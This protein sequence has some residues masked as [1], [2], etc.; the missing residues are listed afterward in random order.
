MDTKLTIKNFRVFDEDGVSI[1]LKPITILTGCN[2]SGKSSLTKAVSLLN[3]FLNQIKKTVDNKE[4]IT[5]AKY[6]LDF[7]T[8][9]NLL[10]G[11]FNR[12]IHEDSSNREVTFEYTVYSRM[13]STDVTVQLNFAIDKNDVL[14]N[15]WLKRMSLSTSEGQFFSTDQENGSIC[16]INLIKE[17]GINF[18]ITEY[19]VHSYCGLRD[20]YDYDQSITKEEFETQKSLIESELNK[21]G[22]DYKKG[23][24]SYVRTT[25]NDKSIIVRCN[26]NPS[27][28]L[29]SK[30]SSSLYMI[31]IIDELNK[32]NKNEVKDWL[33]EKGI[34]SRIKGLKT[35]TNI[36][37]DDFV[38]SEHTCFG[39]YFKHYE[40]LFLEKYKSYKLLSLKEP[41]LMDLCW[42]E[43]DFE[44]VKEINFKYL[45]ES[46][47][48]LNGQL[49]EQKTDYYEK[50]NERYEYNHFMIDRLFHLYVNEMIKEVLTPEWSDN[51]EYA[52]SSRAKIQRLYTLEVDDDFTRLLKKYFEKRREFEN[53]TN[54]L[55]KDTKYEPN[56]F[57]NKWISKFGIGNK[58]ELSTDDFVGLGVTILLHK[59]ENDEKGHL[60]A[61][62]GYGI[63]QLFTVLLQIET[64][65]LSA[66]G[67]RN[68]GYSGL[69]DLDDQTLEDFL[70]GFNYEVNTILIE[71]PEI[72]LHPKFQSMLADMM[73]DA[74]KNYNIHFIVETHSE[75]LI[76]KLQVLVAG[77]N[78]DLNKISL[79]YFDNPN[80][81]KRGS[82][83][84][85]VK[86]I[87]ILPDGR[88][89]D[90]FGEGFFDEA[91]KRAMDLLRIKA[92]QK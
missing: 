22:E 88:L 30:E 58:I 86:A 72:H 67:E 24:C 56:S 3:S 82:H 4:S 40:T 48:L 9:P 8:Y 27:I 70:F 21:C 29:W 66:R 89:S 60:L 45:Y 75:Y 12:V 16:N 35:Y 71:E 80:I 44:S 5:L 63:T 26:A 78:V 76:R 91:D 32:L 47:M 17:A 57:L 64:A 36:I 53:E 68:N 65:I 19:L 37:I 41:S 23:V 6:R 39:D 18:M 31:P 13:L 2:S 69:D 83:T 92:R 38:A 50:S 54:I 87:G 61:D 79:N 90:K 11:N 46:I 52:S 85:Q 1:D 7:T 73:V 15:G 77:N 84:P 74:Y 51:M 49:Y 55:H 28:V 59:T 25:N 10:L 34:F 14:N 42:A 43:T 33:I 62:E 20:A 81:E